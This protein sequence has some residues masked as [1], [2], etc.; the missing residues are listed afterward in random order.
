MARK[1]KIRDPSG[2][3][4]DGTWV[5]I[6]E[7]TERFSD[8][9]LEDGTLLR[10]RTVIQEVFRFDNLWDA[11]GNPVYSVNSATMPTVLESPEV[12]KKPASGRK[13]N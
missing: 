5:G 1:R 3:F 9:K 11:N 8:V 7:S 10:V 6:D 4:V 12:L 13:D 2:N